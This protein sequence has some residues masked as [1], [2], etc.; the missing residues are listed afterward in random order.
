MQDSC[1]G[2]TMTVTIIILL[3]LILLGAF[4]SLIVAILA[5][6]RP[7]RDR[8]KARP[9]TSTVQNQMSVLRQRTNT[10]LQNS[11]IARRGQPVEYIPVEDAP[12]NGVRS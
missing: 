4:S 10:V 11:R 6:R 8:K 3:G 2:V 7:H 9:N 1:G 5:V 12:Y